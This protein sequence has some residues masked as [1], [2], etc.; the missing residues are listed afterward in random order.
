M[1]EC[2]FTVLWLQLGW[3]TG[4]DRVEQ[5]PQTLRLQEGDRVRLNCSYTVSAFNGLQWYRQDPGQG[6]EFLFVL[7]AVGDEKQKE[8]LRATLLKEG[9]SLHIEAS[10]PEDS[11]TYF[12]A[13]KPGGNQYIF[14]KG[15]SLKVLPSEYTDKTL[16]LNKVLVLE[17]QEKVK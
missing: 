14:G 9:S 17:G 7:Y 5:S 4:E 13:V 1:L 11:A 12:C 6:P 2:A 16:F 8:R 10:K 3:V 15:T